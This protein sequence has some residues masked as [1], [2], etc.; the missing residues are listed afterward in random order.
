MVKNPYGGRLSRIDLTPQKVKG[1]VF[2]TRN[3]KPFLRALDAVRAQ[4]V[5]FVLQVTMLNSPTWL[6]RAVPPADQLF[7]TLKVLREI[8]G[9]QCLVWRY[10]PIVLTNLST[11]EWHLGQFY[12]LASSWSGLTD[13]V[14][15]SFVA[16]YRKTRRNL[17]A[18]MAAVGADLLEVSNEE[19]KALLGALKLAALEYGIRLTLCTQPDLESDR[20]AGA[21]CI[22][23]ERLSAIAGRKIEVM[24]R[25]NRPGCLCH[26]SRDIGAYDSCAQ[27]C[28]Y[29]YAVS[30]PSRAITT[31]AAHDPSW[32]SLAGR[33]E[34]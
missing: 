19:K 6:D 16:P 25:G 14:V 31:V 28:A 21:A 4:D 32:N 22:D 2:W 18:A 26:E 11:A 24:R 10:D 29:C 8:Y 7:P 23:V 27:G 34:T 3:P 9:P 33:I 20:V 13:E 1:Y 12:Q 17:G 30:Q 15:V 5:P